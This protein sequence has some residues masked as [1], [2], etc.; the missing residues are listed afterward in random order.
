VSSLF[1]NSIVPAILPSVSLSIALVLTPILGCFLSQ[2]TKYLAVLIASVAL[3]FS[4]L[5]LFSTNVVVVVSGL[6]LMGVAY[7]LT[8]TG[9]WGTIAVY[10]NQNNFGLLYSIPYAVVTRNKTKRFQF[11]TRFFHCFF[12][13]ICSIALFLCPAE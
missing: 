12:S 7:S 5:A 4:C 13:S 3:L 9:V 2:N 8:S 11:L 1:S 10:G 6:V